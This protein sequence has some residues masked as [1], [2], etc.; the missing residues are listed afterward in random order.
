M[1][2][3]VKSLRILLVNNVNNTHNLS[4]RY[5]LKKFDD[6]MM[7]LSSQQHIILHNIDRYTGLML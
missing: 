4:S 1:K 6:N 2:K 7:V 5:Y 3:K